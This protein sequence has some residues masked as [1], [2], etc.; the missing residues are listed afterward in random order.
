MQGQATK[1]WTRNQRPEGFVVARSNSVRS[2]IAHERIHLLAA[3]W[4]VLS[5]PAEGA[6]A[7]SKADW[8][9]NVPLAI[10]V[11]NGRAR[12]SFDAEN[13]GDKVLVIASMM[14]PAASSTTLEIRASHK[15]S[16]APAGDRFVFSA[17]PVL[18]RNRVARP[19]F[20]DAPAPPI[21]ARSFFVLSK[22]G[23]VSSPENYEKRGA[24]L[25]AVG[26]HVQ[27][28]VDDAELPRVS[29]EALKL[30]VA[31]FDET[32]WPRCS[33]SFGPAHDTDGDGRLTVL[34]TAALPLADAS[35]DPVDGMMRD[36]DFD[37]RVAEPLGNACDLI[38]LNSRLGAGPYLQTVLAHEYTHAIIFSRRVLDTR[39]EARAQEEAWLDEGLAHLV[40]DWLGFSEANIARRCRAYLAAP[41]RYRLIVEDYYDEALFRSPGHRGATCLFLR[42]CVGQ[43]GQELL[44]AMIDSRLSGVE[45]VEA[46]TGARFED[47]YRAWTLEQFRRSM[48][49]AATSHKPEMHAHRLSAGAAPQRWRAVAT[50]PRYTIV[51]ATQPGPLEIELQ[52]DAAGELQVTAVRLPAD[53][54]PGDD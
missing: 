27:V 1:E 5:M 53:F 17:K 15:P 39:P 30:V 49:P 33:A 14:R 4:V 40:E 51:S 13:A 46:A 43:C 52:A 28:Y 35:Q 54:G 37:A 16:S 24:R 42:F 41:E 2:A 10:P 32:I 20:E 26:R 18:E 8:P 34:F 50:A 9:A 25:R 31:T 44:P 29:D 47:L 38:L 45:N 11:A 48:E 23:A 3:I 7:N 19:A 6:T 36:A 22:E 21:S 12:L